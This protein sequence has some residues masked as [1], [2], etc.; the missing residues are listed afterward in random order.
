MYSVKPGRGPS[1]MGGIASLVIMI[2]GLCFAGEFLN[3]NPPPPV[4]AFFVVWVLFGIS[5]AI[6]GFYNAFAKNRFSEHDITKPQTEPDPIAKAL[7]FEQSANVPTQGNIPPTGINYCPFCGTR[8]S[9]DYVCC[10]VCGKNLP[11]GVEAK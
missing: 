2:L 3:T 8:V 11:T 9:P 6:G 5:G 1:L 7:G 10:P 4:K